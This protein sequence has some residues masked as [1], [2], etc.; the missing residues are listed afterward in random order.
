MF[1]NLHYFSLLIVDLAAGL[2]TDSI[3]PL[4]SNPAVVRELQQ[5]LPSP[6]DD[7]GDP[8]E[9]L[10]LTLTSPQFQQ[11]KKL[12]C[13]LLLL[14][15][16]FLLEIRLETCARAYRK[17]PFY[18]GDVLLSGKHHIW[19]R[20]NKKSIVA[21]VTVFKFGFIACIEFLF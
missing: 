14:Y 13:V 1:Y 6:I 7:S 9:Q 10:R 12:D 20:P 5:H 3:Q 15:R 17:G 16:I 2:N 21:L 8:Q 4:L 11:V 18:K 19:Y